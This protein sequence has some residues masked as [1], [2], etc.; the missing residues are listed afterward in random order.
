MDHEKVRDTRHKQEAK[1]FPEEAKGLTQKQE[2]GVNPPSNAIANLCGVTPHSCQYC[3]EFF[4]LDFSDEL[5][6]KAKQSRQRFE[7]QSQDDLETRPG[8]R[9][10]RIESFD[11]FLNVDS[12]DVQLGAAMGCPL[13]GT[14]ND[15]MKSQ[16][17]STAQFAMGVKLI[18]EMHLE[19][20]LLEYDE[21][22]D[23]YTG[24][25][26]RVR[27][28][29]IVQACKNHDDHIASKETQC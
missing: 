24:H 21:M 29:P 3:R 23:K 4:A 25:F 14:W 18:R 5:G 11:T 17:N 28:K 7:K 10:R 15:V 13:C 8:A 27:Y 12:K 22:L 6:E 1:S 9:H 2:E 19:I 26:P 16:I 20:W